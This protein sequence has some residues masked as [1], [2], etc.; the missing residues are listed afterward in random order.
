MA[1]PKVD[2]PDFYNTEIQGQTSVP[3]ECAVFLCDRLSNRIMFTSDSA[4][5]TFLP[6]VTRAERRDLQTRSRY[7]WELTEQCPD[8]LSYNFI[9]LL[10]LLNGTDEAKKVQILRSRWTR[11][12]T[13]SLRTPVTS[14]P[15][16]RS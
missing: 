5:V 11:W 13:R 1:A 10:G 8:L 9:G 12:R 15:Q 2:A 16:S 14:A 3:M 7:R 6:Y 4:L